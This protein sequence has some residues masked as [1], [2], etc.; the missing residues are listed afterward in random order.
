MP[1]LRMRSRSTSP[2]AASRRGTRSDAT[3]ASARLASP[4]ALAPSPH[5]A[6][7]PP[8]VQPP[9]RLDRGQLLFRTLGVA[10]IHVGGVGV[11]SPGAERMF[12][13][14]ALTAMAPDHVLAREEV[15]ALVWPGSDDESARHSLRQHLY[16][17]RHWGIPLRSTRAS[18][19]LDPSCLVPCF[20]LDRTAR[21]F[22]EDVLRGGEPFGQLFAGWIPSQLAMRRW[23][24][25]QRD[26]FQ[27]DVRRILVPEL[28]RLRDRADWVECERWARTV[29]EFDPYNEDGMLV[30]AEAIAMQG[31]RYSA[32]TMLDGYVRE[33]GI[34]GTDLAQDVEA[35]QRRI[36]KA[37]RVRHEASATPTLVG[38]DEELRQLDAI[39]L[40]ALQGQTQVVQITGP[41]G[42]G[43]TELAYEA[44]RRAVILGFTRCIVRVTR[45]MG[46]MPL[47][48]LSRL[49]RDLLRL[50]GALGCRPETLEALSVI[51]GIG[52]VADS[53]P[54]P[55]APAVSIV[56]CV[57][58]LVRA[59]ADEAPLVLL[60]DSPESVD[61]ASAGI[62]SSAIELVGNAQLLVLVPSSTVSDD[63]TRRPMFSAPST[64]VRLG[65]LSLPARVKL[66]SDVVTST[67]RRLTEEQAKAAVA[68]SDGTPLQVI[69]AARDAL[70]RGISDPPAIRLQ[71]SLR[72]QV[73]CLP[74]SAFH[75]LSAI[76]LIGGE[77]AVTDLE[78]FLD[79]PLQERVDAIRHL[80]EA[81]LV[82]DDAAE[83][84]HMQPLLLEVVLSEAS[85][86]EQ[87]LIALQIIDRISASLDR[88]FIPKLATVAF[89]LAQR[90]APSITKV[91]LCLRFSVLLA[92]S[93]LARQ[94][95]EAIDDAL[96]GVNHPA[97]KAALLECQLQVSR[98]AADWRR[99]LTASIDLGGLLPTSALTDP[100]IRVI[101]LEAKLRSDLLAYGHEN[102]AEALE[103]ASD[104]D[105]AIEVRLRAARL[106]ISTA[107]D[108]FNRDLAHA[109]YCQLVLVRDAM[110]EDSAELKEALLQYHAIFGEQRESVR[111]AKGIVESLSSATMSPDLARMAS[112]AAYALRL[113]GECKLAGETFSRLYHEMS[114]IG[115]PGRR[116]VAAWQL[117][118]IH[119]D[120]N[121]SVAALAWGSCL[122]AIVE[123]ELNAS[124]ELWYTNHRLRL[125]LVSRGFIERGRSLLQRID[126][127]RG[128]PTRSMLYCL[129]LALSS[130]DVGAMP[131]VRHE[132]SL[133][134]VSLLRQYGAFGGMDLLLV[135]VANSLTALGDTEVAQD[136]V[137]RFLLR[138]RRER[139]G[140]V[141]LIARLPSGLK[142]VA[143]AAMME[144][145]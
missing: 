135:A 112:N 125:E 40:A 48:M 47:G 58:E 7:L 117:S 90:Y 118:L 84:V 9:P 6:P 92:T 76:A 49:V 42:I 53:T 23:V 86:L 13:L 83:S 103:L 43:K 129:G 55:K 75:V 88:C 77:C 106:V 19:M 95:S 68:N 69:A 133:E 89:S 115:A 22:D 82:T 26:R 51:S 59:L 11:I 33:T 136:V 25:E 79:L 38:R 46:Q 108:L 94:A 81:A 97:E 45:P 64:E 28:R 17:L 39:T 37:T 73:S 96:S 134:A 127:E 41:A 10:E 144:E 110:S 107:S 20:A 101:G 139:G 65:P 74:P 2:A 102:A 34:T 145:S 54:K 63:V 1:L 5:D 138:D 128:R 14:L 120:R 36:G 93:G 4:E 78:I 109:A 60:L 21:R 30:L 130:R 15:L 85:R 3:A 52:E 50:P 105:A 67:G 32:R 29:L 91:A 16:K 137:T 12:S 80:C 24:E 100:R 99:V 122:S 123:N 142:Q 140:I 132:L 61:E 18:V 8:G 114:L 87:R 131:R 116:A 141:H 57:S 71:E 119:A 98:A 124:D 72:K 62:V 126:A 104:A 31:S 121:E 143:E 113:G 35:A 111:I 70:T 44:T 56:E 27:M 66:A